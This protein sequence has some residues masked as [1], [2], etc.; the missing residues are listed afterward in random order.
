MTRITRELFVR[1][2]RQGGKAKGKAKRRGSK[3]HYAELG[4][5]GAAARWGGTP[6]PFKEVERFPDGPEVRVAKPKPAG[7][8]S[9]RGRGSR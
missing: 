8:A 5:R 6:A 7:R 1:T 4:K 9:G 3:R 2:G